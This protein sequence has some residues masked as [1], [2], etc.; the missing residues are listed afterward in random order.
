[1]V[2]N[3]VAH[4]IETEV[5]R[6]MA[7]KPA[8]GRL[9][10]EIS[11]RAS[12][13]WIRCHDDGAGID[14]E[15][16]RRVLKKT[17][18]RYADTQGLDA[19]ALLALLLKGGMGGIS[20]SSV[21]TELSGRGVGLDVVRDA[22]Q[23]LNGEI[24]AHTEQ[25][26]GTS[27]ELS[28]PLSLA[29]LEVLMIMS[30]GEPLALP[31]DAV[32]HTMR[33]LPEDIFRTPMG[34]AI[35]YQGKQIPLAHLQLGT[36]ADKTKGKGPRASAAMTA[37]VMAATDHIAAIAVDRLQ[38]IE[39]IVLRPLPKLAPADPIVMGIHLDDEGNP[40]IVLDPEQIVMRQYH[41]AA[42][43][44]TPVMQQAPLRPILVIDDSL[45]TRML[46][47]SIL[48]SAGF[49]VETAASAEEGLDM[50][51]RNTYA[52]FLVDVE[53]PGMDGFGFVARTRS[54]AALCDI[55]CILVTSRNAPEDRQRGNDCGAADYIV[56]GEFDQVDFLQRISHLVQR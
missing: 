38:G 14:L 24:Y 7:G 17:D 12:R 3:A 35:V 36:R 41:A 6:T 49:T 56:K 18:G 15:A 51:F 46:E 47:C 16:L 44:A 26:C 21:V 28:V 42:E 10:L 53:M 4:G 5:Q 29:A 32:R 23:R 45:T 54:E 37:I 52:L 50:A 20:T 40:R 11:R 31:L 13:I 43:A 22:M 34:E 27:V 39:M 33:V 9:T 1:L 55:P 2:R 48:E 8:A 25:G 30:N 19:Q